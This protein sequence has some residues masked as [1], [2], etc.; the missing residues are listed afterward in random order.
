[1]IAKFNKKINKDFLIKVVFQIIS[2]IIF[3]II[4]IL[5]LADFKIYKNKKELKSQLDFYQ[6][7]IEEIKKNN[8]SLGEQIENIGNE[9][10][11]EKIAYEQ[12]ML[13]VGEKGVIFISP[14]SKENEISE[15]KNIWQNYND[16]LLKIWD[17]IKSKF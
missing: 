4:F 13:R 14:E 3:I 10:Y 7:K 11:L 9:D 1:M 12:G 8:K 16:W 15:N 6:K 17:W 2:V 5:I